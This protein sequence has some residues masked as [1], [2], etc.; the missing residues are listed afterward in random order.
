M[1]TIIAGGRDNWL[2]LDDMEWLDCIHAATPISEVVCGM[3]AGADCGGYFWSCWRLK[4]EPTKFPYLREFGKAGGPI[5]N[6]QMAADADALVIFP[7]GFGSA[8]MI[9]NAQLRGLRIIYRN[10][11]RA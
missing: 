10:S 7:G 1:K 3:A 4:K 2:T 9:R 6:A 8:N 11:G 5:R